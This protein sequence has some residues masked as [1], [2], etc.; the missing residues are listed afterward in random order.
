MKM[1][2]KNCDTSQEGVTQNGNKILV[3]QK[4]QTMVIVINV[5]V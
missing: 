4:S 2:R 1:K 5:P 3:K